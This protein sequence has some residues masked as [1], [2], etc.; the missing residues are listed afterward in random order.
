M[1]EILGDLW[2]YGLPAIVLITTNGTVKKP[3]G[4]CVMGR[5]CALEAKMRFPGIARRLGQQIKDHGNRVHV[6]EPG[7]IWSFPVKHNWWDTA[8]LALIAQ[9]AQE[10][11]AE[12]VTRDTVRF[13][14]PRPGCGNGKLG[15]WQVRPVPEK[16]LPDN[17]FVIGK[18]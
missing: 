3:S 15:W 13:I 10:L 11:A 18:I 12:A 5:G 17:V 2:D 6:L 4:E 1:R 14:L 9:S 16:L 7:K 8:D